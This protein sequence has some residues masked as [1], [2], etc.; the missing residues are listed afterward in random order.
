LNEL[1]VLNSTESDT[2]LRF[3]EAIQGIAPRDIFHMIL[4]TVYERKNI[5]HNFF[6]VEI[7]MELFNIFKSFFHNYYSDMLTA[8][9]Q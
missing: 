9:E 4:S 7:D 8:T 2:L 5:F 6:K 3:D 1:A